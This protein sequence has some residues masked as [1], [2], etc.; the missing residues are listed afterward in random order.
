MKPLCS[1]LL[2]LLPAALAAQ[3]HIF[4]VDSKTSEVA[5]TLGDVL[6]TVHGVFQIQSGS[7]AF[8]SGSSKISGSIIV[9]AGSGN[10][11][12]G[13]RDKRM[14]KDILDAPHFNEITFVPQSYEGGLRSSGISTI[15]V[16]GIFTLH[17][18]PHEI[19]VPMQVDIDGAKCRA[20]TRFPVPYVK[21]GLK[22]PSTFVLKVGKEVEIDLKLA[23]SIK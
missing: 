18:V 3:S 5:F 15:Q 12:G 11:G 20:Q 6:H 10:S 9:A 13:A 22:D 8:D 7:I 19:T 17:G 4:T 1:F 23:G 21:W 14:T 16:K 2:C